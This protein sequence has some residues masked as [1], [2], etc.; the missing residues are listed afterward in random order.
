MHYQDDWQD[1]VDEYYDALKAAG[2]ET[3]AAEMQRQIDEWLAA[4]K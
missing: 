3:V 1:L 2:I 4:N